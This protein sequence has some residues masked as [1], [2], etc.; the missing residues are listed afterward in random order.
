MIETLFSFAHVFQKKN[1][2]LI[3]ETTL[4]SDDQASLKQPKNSQ[5]QLLYMYLTTVHHW[6]TVG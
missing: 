3:F 5:G 1:T 2:E 4:L 6:K